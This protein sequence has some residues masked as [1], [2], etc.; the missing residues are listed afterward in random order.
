MDNKRENENRKTKQEVE[1]YRE[2]IIDMVN[3]IKD[4]RLLKRIYELAEYL[5]IYK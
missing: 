2:K 5:Y 1:W 3:Q 4:E